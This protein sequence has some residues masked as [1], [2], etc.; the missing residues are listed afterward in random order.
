[1]SGSQKKDALAEGT[2]SKTASRRLRFT[3]TAVD[4]LLNACL[5]FRAR[6]SHC[7]QRFARSDMYLSH[8][9]WG[10]HFYDC[11]NLGWDDHVLGFGKLL[12]SVSDIPG[13][14]LLATQF[15]TK[16][17]LDPH[18]PAMQGVVLAASPPE[19]LQELQQ[20]VPVCRRAAGRVRVPPI[21]QLLV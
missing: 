12:R 20:Y 21:P 9:H 10:L 13:R 17:P 4:V 16:K 5:L 18:H 6:V 15:V 11:F 7:G 8:N 2:Q 19:T 14:V 3:G 1:M